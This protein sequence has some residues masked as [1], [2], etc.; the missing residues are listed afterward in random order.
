MLGNV[1]PPGTALDRVLLLT[2]DGSGFLQVIGHVGHTTH[3]LAMIA[4]TVG[5][6]RNEV[7]DRVATGE[8]GVWHPRIAA[9]NNSGGAQI[10]IGAFI[11]IVRHAIVVVVV[12]NLERERVELTFAN[13]RGGDL[14]PAQVSP[15]RAGE[16]DR[17]GVAEW[18]VAPTVG[19]D[20]GSITIAWDAVEADKVEGLTGAQVELNCPQTDSEVLEVQFVE[21]GDLI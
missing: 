16:V 13:R 3:E 18:D 7:R 1:C 6:C 4:G 12:G 8:Q 15:L 19:G 14:D 21:T 20:S 11:W 17:V 10:G 9:I 2:R 5:A